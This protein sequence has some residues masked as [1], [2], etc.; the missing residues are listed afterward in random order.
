MT[1]LEQGIDRRRFIRN[2]GIGSALVWSAP[3]VTT[4]GQVHAASSPPGCGPDFFTDFDNA[5][6]ARLNATGNLDG[7]TVTSGSVDVI[8][9]GFFDFYPGNGLYIDTDGSG[10]APGQPRIESIATFGAGTYV[11]EFVLAGS[12]RGDANRVAVQFGAN[13]EIVNLGSSAPPTTFS[14]TW[15]L[16]VPAR[17]TFTH[18]EPPDFLGLILLSASVRCT[19]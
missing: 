6:P 10:G 17:L 3:A 11:V 18:A 12:T 14:R 19:A 1:D 7:F 9:N 4:L 13:T 2:A 16:L 5:G 15:S 8:G